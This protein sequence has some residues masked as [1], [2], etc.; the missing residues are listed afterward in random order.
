MHEA[1]AK[2]NFEAD[3]AKL[4][5]QAAQRVGLEIHARAFPIFD[6]TVLHSKPLRLRLNGATWDELPVSVD[7]LNPDGSYYAGTMPGD[8]FHQGPHPRTGRPFVCMRGT[9]EYHTHSSHLG[10]LWENYRGQ[11]GMNIP[12]IV[13]QI[14]RV[15]RRMVK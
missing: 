6:V 8:I 12:G 13:M 7:L 15:W 10:D 4:S 2:A 14:G 9:L 11:D 5:N 3:V 1:L